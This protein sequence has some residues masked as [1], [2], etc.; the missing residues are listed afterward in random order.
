M[1]GSLLQ[2][3]I[4]RK[5]ALTAN[6]C[7]CHGR[8][9]VQTFNRC[10]WSILFCC[11]RGTDIIVP[12]AGLCPKS[13]S[14]LFCSLPLL[15]TAL[16][17]CVTLLSFSFC[18]SHLPGLL[19][20]LLLTAVASSKGYPWNMGNRAGTSRVK[21]PLH[22]ILPQNFWVLH[23]SWKK[24]LALQHQPELLPLRMKFLP[25][26]FPSPSFSSAVSPL[27]C[28]RARVCTSILNATFEGDGWGLLVTS[29]ESLS[30]I[31]LTSAFSP[32]WEEGWEIK[33]VSNLGQKYFRDL[34]VHMFA[35][36]E[37]QEIQLL[38]LGLCCFLRLAGNNLERNA[39]PPFSNIWTATNYT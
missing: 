37:Y 5:L 31:W 24:C 21:F 36:V 12:E 27:S 14:K 16:T 7:R 23:H 28:S 1:T 11:W 29:L 22:S 39:F 30:T 10:C 26:P 25:L 34:L 2:P 9:T 15:S 6:F 3:E 19:R 17:P 13:P 32:G 35:E 8:Q 18:M 33:K 4:L 38:L 20:M